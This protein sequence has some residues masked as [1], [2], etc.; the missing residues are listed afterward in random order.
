MKQL[1]SFLFLSLNE[2]NRHRESIRAD[3]ENMEVE[4]LLYFLPEYEPCEPS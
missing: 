4:L 1:V 2:L 3:E